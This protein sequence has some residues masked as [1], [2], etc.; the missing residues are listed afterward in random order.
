MPL[1]FLLAVF[2]EMLLLGIFS[3]FTKNNVWWQSRNSLRNFMI[4][5]F[6][7]VIIAT[8]L[9]SIFYLIEYLQ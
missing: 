5:I 1:T 7:L 4:V 3:R 9:P 6:I 2:I 8:I